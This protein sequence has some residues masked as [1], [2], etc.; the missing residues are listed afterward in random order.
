M[1][2][3]PQIETLARKFRASRLFIK[4]GTCR[5]AVKTTKTVAIVDLSVKDREVSKFAIRIKGSALSQAS[6][7]I[8]TEHIIGQKHSTLCAV[9][10]MLWLLLKRGEPVWEGSPFH[11]LN[12]FAEYAGRPELHNDIL[13]PFDAAICAIHNS[14]KLRRQP[15]GKV[16]VWFGKFD[17]KL[18]YQNFILEHYN[19][20]DDDTPLNEFAASQGEVWYDHDWLECQFFED[21]DWEKKFFYSGSPLQVGSVNEIISRAKKLSNTDY[22][23][24]FSYIEPHCTPNT[25]EFSNPTTYKSE[26]AELLFIGS[27]EPNSHFQ[28]T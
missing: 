26:T 17:S 23:A 15:Y 24:F 3:E 19:E 12:I 11:Q 28:Y 14:G 4:D 25:I 9:H 27:F 5:K 20:T 6:G 18:R 21:D 8:L 10:T 7:S 13:L 22:N 1:K 2:L 16:H